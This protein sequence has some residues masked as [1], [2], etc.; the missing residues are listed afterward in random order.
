[1]RLRGN[2]MTVPASKAELLEAI[3]SSFDK[4]MKELATVP[5]G[6]TAEKTLEGHAKGS[7][8]SVHDL[9][10]YL[11]GWNEL[12]L[13]WHDRRDAVRLRVKLQALPPVR[14]PGARRPSPAQRANRRSFL[15]RKTPWTPCSPVKSGYLLHW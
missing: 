11:T 13:K 3:G 1:M 12:V 10:A 9:V 14:R 7:H 8:M 6:R 15:R 4:L 5:T 2:Q